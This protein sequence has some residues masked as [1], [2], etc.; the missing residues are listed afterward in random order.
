MRSELY[1]EE[2]FTTLTADAGIK[3]IPRRSTD[4]ETDGAVI[5]SH[6]RI[7]EELYIEARTS[8]TLLQIPLLMEWKKKH[9]NLLLVVR[10]LTPKVKQR[11]RE[12]HINYLEANGNVYLRTDQL[13]IYKDDPKAGRVYQEQVKGRAF[14]KTGLKLVFHFLLHE[15]LVNLTYRQM[16]DITGVS[17][18]NINI[19]VTDL[20]EQGFI[21]PIG[22]R[23]YKLDNKAK[24]L[25]RWIHGFEQKLRP[26][27]TMGKFR[28]LNQQDFYDWKN[29]PVEPGVQQ[30]GGEAGGHFLTGYLQPEML[31]LYTQSGTRDLLKKFRLL[32][33]PEGNVEICQKFW[34]DEAIPSIHVPA[35]LIYIDLMLKGDRRCIE[36]AQKIWN[37]ELRGK[38]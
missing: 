7:K 27:I 38:F 32:P 5:L 8:L 6:G 16:A 4:R 3:V 36:T 23:F 10:R 12:H 22:K 35:L 26:A 9:P 17:F 13:F 25:E 34:Y 15:E 37:N 18:G 14:T 30:W 11:L 21:V 29:L 2:A 1:I 24:L 31:T 19:I 28:F 33:D 20:K